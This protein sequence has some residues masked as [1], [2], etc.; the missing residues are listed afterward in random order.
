MPKLDVEGH[1]PIVQVQKYLTWSASVVCQVVEPVVALTY[2]QLY[3][4]YQLEKGGQ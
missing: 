3:Y 4:Y 1:G 2:V